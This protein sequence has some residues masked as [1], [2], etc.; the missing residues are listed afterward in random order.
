MTLITVP[1]APFE[2]NRPV[3][4]VDPSPPSLHFNV[5]STSPPSCTPTATL[6]HL[7]DQ[8]TPTIPISHLSQPTKPTS[9]PQ[10]LPLDKPHHRTTTCLH[11]ITSSTFINQP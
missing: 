1:T 11:L 3:R 5:T 4:I 9:S 6:A 10:L 7:P 8:P 2:I